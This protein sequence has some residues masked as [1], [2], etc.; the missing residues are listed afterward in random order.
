VKFEALRIV[1]ALLRDA[2]QAEIMPRFRNL[3][4]GDVREKTGPLDLVTEADEAAEARITADLLREFPGCVMVGEEAASA[5]PA[6]LPGLTSAELGFVIDPVDGTANF[7]AGLALFGVMVA[8]FRRG[9]IIGAVIHDPIGDDHA[10]ALRGEGAWIETSDGMRRDLR[11]AAPAPAARMGGNV[12]WRFMPKQQRYE[13]AARLP[14]MAAC[15]DYRCSAHAYRMTAAGHGHF[16]FYWRLYPWD[17][18]PGW[19]LHQEAGGYSA[20]FDGRPY[21]PVDIYSGLICAPDRAGWEAVHAALLE[22]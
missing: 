5:N 1:A 17:H 18:A 7:A 16:L 6:I 15:W 11:V 2:A 21:D 9:E 13:V 4:A 20:R 12:S 19:L 22:G 10:M 14:R 8:V 3:S